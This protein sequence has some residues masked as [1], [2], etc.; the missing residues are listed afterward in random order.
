MTKL[1][2][3]VWNPAGMAPKRAF[4]EMTWASKTP[5]SKARVT[6]LCHREGATMSD[7]I[8]TAFLV[9]AGAL[10]VVIS[11]I[12][13]A[14]IPEEIEAETPKTVECIEQSGAS[15]DRD[16]RVAGYKATKCAEKSG[17]APP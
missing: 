1:A 10:V 11:Y 13:F 4:E 12:V 5:W 9:A 8:A 7:K 14:T 15:K 17:A 16:Y 3:G 6:A 2:D